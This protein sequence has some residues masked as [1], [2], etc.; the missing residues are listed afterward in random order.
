MATQTYWD[1][2]TD[3]V[4]QVWLSNTFDDWTKE[5]RRIKRDI[6]RMLKQAVS[7]WGSYLK[8]D[9]VLISS[10]TVADQNNYNIPA[11]IDKVSLIKIT[12][13]WVDYFPIEISINEFNTLINDTSSTSDVP[14]FFTIDKNQIYIYPTPAS[15][16]NP[17][18]VNGSVYIT[19]LN[20][21]PSLTTD[22]NT[23]LDIKEG[24]EN[25]IYYYALY[26]A[27]MRL[28]D[29]VLAGE[30]KLEH[31]KVMR[32]YKNKVKN[33]TNNPVVKT[34]RTNFVNPN[35]YFTIT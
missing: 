9:G 6:N 12:S 4:D 2:F 5:T 22:Q 24:F 32:E 31:E 1:M 29:S 35:E 10:W 8:K 17:I 15:N 30:F 26:M 25:V 11:T 34:W 16:S 18:E 21:D 27:Y 14:V 20:T 28:E 19:D 13:W 3:V 7:I 23:V 33:T